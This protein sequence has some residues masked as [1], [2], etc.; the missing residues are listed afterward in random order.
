MDRRIFT[1]N[2][3]L[4]IGA[5]LERVLAG[6]DPGRLHDLVAAVAAGVATDGV[7]AGC[8]GGDGGLF[9]G[10]TAR[11]LAAVARDLPGADERARRTRALAADLVLASADAAWANRVEDDSGVFFGADWTAPARAGLSLWLGDELPALFRLDEDETPII[12]LT[13]K[14]DETDKVLG[15][16]LGA[17]DYVTKPFGMK[18]LTARIHAGR[19][20]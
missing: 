3:G 4:V 18:E 7:L 2:Q 6:G 11:Y 9:A 8:G 19:D 13:A 5:E 12:L 20:V 15:L 16:E 10:I 17:D 1:Y 14:L